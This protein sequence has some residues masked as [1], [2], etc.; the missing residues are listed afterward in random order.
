[1]MFS[2]SVVEKLSEHEGTTIGRLS[3][4]SHADSFKAMMAATSRVTHNAMYFM[5][6]PSIARL[7]ID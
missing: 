4:E 2:T 3:T 5:A 1:M 6:P 7:C